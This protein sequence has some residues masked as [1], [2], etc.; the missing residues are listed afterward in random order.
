MNDAYRNHIEVDIETASTMQ[1]PEAQEHPPPLGRLADANSDGGID[2]TFEMDESDS[3]DSYEYDSPRDGIE[4]GVESIPVREQEV[5][6]EPIEEDD[7]EGCTLE[8]EDVTDYDHLFD[9]ES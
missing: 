6:D 8:K 5:V 4:V 7:E 1:R 9:L 2:S 3:Y